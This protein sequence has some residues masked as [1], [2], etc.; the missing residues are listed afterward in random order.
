MPW[1]QDNIVTV[2]ILTFVAWVIWGRVVQP[3][4]LGIQRMTAE[5]YKSFKDEPHTLVDVRSIGEWNGGRASNAI[6]IP[7]DEVNRRLSRIPKDKPV[8]LIC[9]SGMRSGM[10]A[11]M[12]AKAGYKSVYNFAGGMGSWSAAKLPTKS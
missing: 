4:L 10:A 1:L 9:A 11:K 7:L 3:K 8:I 5:K 12:L 6:H 2:L